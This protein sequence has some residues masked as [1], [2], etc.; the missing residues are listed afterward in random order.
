MSVAFGVEIG[1]PLQNLFEY[2]SKAMDLKTETSCVI[3][4]VVME[5]A[6]HE[7]ETEVYDGCL[8]FPPF[9]VGY[10]V[11][12]QDVL[13]VESLQD[14]DLAKSCDRKTQRGFLLDMHHLFEGI[15]SAVFIF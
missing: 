5:I 7:I 14:L 13:M 10:F 11:N 8:I 9:F 6:L 3:V 4:D 1:D 2:P 12:V 15:L